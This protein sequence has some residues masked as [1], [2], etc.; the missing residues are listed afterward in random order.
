MLPSEI[1]LFSTLHMDMIRLDTRELLKHVR[2]FLIS[3]SFP[4]GTL[5]ARFICYGHLLNFDSE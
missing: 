5:L 2:F 4:T 3:E 1:I